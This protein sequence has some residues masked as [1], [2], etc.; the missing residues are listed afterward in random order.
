[1]LKYN[2]VNIIRAVKTLGCFW[3]YTIPMNKM[4]EQLFESSGQ[5]YQTLLFN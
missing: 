3:K 4:S 1:M 5:N 2:Y